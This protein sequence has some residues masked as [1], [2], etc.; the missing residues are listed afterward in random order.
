M[1]AKFPREQTGW[2]GKTAGQPP[3][4][5]ESMSTCSSC[6][7]PRGTVNSI[8]RFAHI[9]SPLE[10]L[11]PPIFQVPSGGARAQGSAPPQRALPASTDQMQCA[12]DSAT[13][14]QNRKSS[15]PSHD[16]GFVPQNSPGKGHKSK[17]VNSSH[18]FRARP[19]VP[20]LLKEH[21]TPSKIHVY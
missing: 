17:A 16:Q 5:V 1:F 11:S 6:F 12:R 13:A 8:K 3:A 19:R 15:T 21:V 18:K 2:I 10:P 7:V 4:I 20:L 14:E 9:G